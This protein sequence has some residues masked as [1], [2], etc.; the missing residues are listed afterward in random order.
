M[1]KTVSVT[2]LEPHE[3]AAIAL[4]AGTDTQIARGGGQTFV[5]T[6]TNDLGQISA[7][8]QAAF[9]ALQAAGYLGCHDLPSLPANWLANSMTTWGS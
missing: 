1:L 6:K 2:I 5:T 4:V 8:A 9:D 3:T 7:S